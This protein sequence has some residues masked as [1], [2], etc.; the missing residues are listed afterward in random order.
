MAVL[1][2]K[3][4]D[5][6]SGVFEAN[7]H[8]YKVQV[9]QITISRFE[10]YEKLAL[11]IGISATF[12]DLFNSVKSIYDKLTTCEIPMKG[13]HESSVIAMNLLHGLKKYGDGEP[14]QVLRFCTLFINREGED[15]T[16]WDEHMAKDKITDWEKEGIAMAD[17]FLLATGA[18]RG[19][20]SAF[21]AIDEIPNLKAPLGD[22]SIT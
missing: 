4:I 11:E 18:I 14:H 3:R 8:I 22:T 9:D 5:I 6:K 10:I 16:K 2:A 20:T 7:G 19:F 1:E 17:F 12:E 13:N 15:L 21:K